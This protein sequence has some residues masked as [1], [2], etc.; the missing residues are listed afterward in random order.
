ML[1]SGLELKVGLGLGLGL[2]LGFMP[3]PISC[4]NA[5]PIS[6]PAPYKPHQALPPHKRNSSLRLIQA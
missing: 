1:E 3:C 4:R 2:G 5:C 6:P